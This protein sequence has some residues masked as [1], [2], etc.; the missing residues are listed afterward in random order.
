MVITAASVK[1]LRDI[2][3]AGMMDAKKA[4]IETGGDKEA[5]IDWLR[6]KGL[7][8]AAKKSGRIA[9]EGLVSV[10]ISDE[11]A[12]LIEINSETD[13]VAKNSHFQ[14]M[15]SNI[16][17]AAVNVSSLEELKNIKIDNQSIDDLITDNI[18]K[19]GENIN[20]R[21]LLKID[22]GNFSSYV[23]N[24]AAENMGKIGV[25]VSLSSHNQELGRQLA[26]HVAAS[27]PASLS[28]ND[29]SQELIA[30][31][32]QILT[33]QAKES[34]K[35]DSVIESMIAG[36]MKKFFEEVTLLNQKF[37]INPQVTVKQV[38]DE[39][40]L[41]INSFARLEVGEGIDK[42]D[43]DFAAEV[44]KTANV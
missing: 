20:L 36:R 7:A 22:G 39:S 43:E 18:A 2:S 32:K 25:V 26:M 41:S 38:L 11:A 29:L 19:I 21:R 24:P 44:E 27:N 5:A 12:V 30:R 9:T 15:V 42:I 40:N 10:R 28:E 17:D 35:P 16:S 14:N 33:E 34:G 13:F 8:K 6:S 3:G 4:L 37:V 31:E 23:H 1:E